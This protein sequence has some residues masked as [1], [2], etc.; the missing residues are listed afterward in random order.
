MGI[1]IATN[2]Q[3]RINKVVSAMAAISDRN[4]S[5]EKGLLL[6]I[7]SGSWMPEWMQELVSSFFSFTFYWH[8]HCTWQQTR[9]HRAL[10]EPEATCNLQ[11]PTSW[12]SIADMWAHFLKP[13]KECWEKGFTAQVSGGTFQIQNIS[14]FQVSFTIINYSKYLVKI[15][16][17][18]QLHFKGVYLLKE[19]LEYWIC[20]FG[21]GRMNI[22]LC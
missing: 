12:L 14:I 18:Q 17:A 5:R 1:W 16:L 21:F 11:R 22:L 7:V 20:K 4:N 15:T 10:Q 9:T 6:L 13:A 3:E 2:F 19:L 8:C